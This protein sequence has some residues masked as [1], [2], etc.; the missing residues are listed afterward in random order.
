MELQFS[1]VGLQLVSQ[2]QT[3]LQQALFGSMLYRLRLLGL[4]IG[5]S[6]GVSRST[7]NVVIPAHQQRGAGGRSA[8]I[9]FRTIL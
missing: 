2:S 3:K 5:L 8:P 4:A 9:F 7:E 6:L 1:E